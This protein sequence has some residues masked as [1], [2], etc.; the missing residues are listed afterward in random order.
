M[1]KVDSH[2][3]QQEELSPEQTRRQFI[4]KFGKLAA[5]TPVAITALISPSTSAAPKSCGV[6][7]NSNAKRCREN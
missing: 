5:V 7:N 6:D 2:S 3:S 1:T 4:E